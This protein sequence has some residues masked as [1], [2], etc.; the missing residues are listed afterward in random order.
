MSLADSF[1]S[2]PDTNDKGRHERRMRAV[3]DLQLEPSTQFNAS[4]SVEIFPPSKY[5]ALGSFD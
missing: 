5:V 3:C 4:S 2:S 1:H